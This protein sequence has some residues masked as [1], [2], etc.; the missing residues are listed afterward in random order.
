MLGYS[1]EL[2]IVGIM[3]FIGIALYGWLD[4]RRTVRIGNF[5]LAMVKSR[6][7]EARHSKSIHPR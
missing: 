2:V 7:D 6:L 4:Y 1:I 5:G 3:L